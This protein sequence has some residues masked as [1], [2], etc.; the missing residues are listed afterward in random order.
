[1]TI[2]ATYR[3][4][5]FY[6]THPISLPENTRVEVTL[7]AEAPKPLTR[8]EILALRPK[9]PKFTGEQLDALIEA[10][11]VSVGS[12]PPDFSRADIYSDHD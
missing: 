9:A 4:G 8:E 3:D 11:H 5:A 7:P 2:E 6:P 1:M 12:L 10:N